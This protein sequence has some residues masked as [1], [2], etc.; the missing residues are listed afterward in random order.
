[1]EDKDI[2][3]DI[4]EEER[5]RVLKMVVET[6]EMGGTEP[7]LV[8]GRDAGYPDLIFGY[9]GIGV[10]IWVI[11]GGVMS[12]NVREKME[13]FSR[14]WCIG[15]VSTQK[16]FMDFFEKLRSEYV[17]FGEGVTVG[18]RKLKDSMSK[19]LMKGVGLGEY[20]YI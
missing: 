14:G 18:V 11:T 5:V 20:K 6:L 13:K 10:A 17:V 8:G 16:E 19:K 9:S 7:M 1:M 15:M 12:D 3:W 4:V 2:S